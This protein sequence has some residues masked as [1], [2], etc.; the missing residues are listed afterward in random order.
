GSAA[1]GR[2]AA[3]AYYNPAAMTLLG[4]SE[5]LGG[6]AIVGPDTHFSASSAFD[7]AGNRIT[8][9]STVRNDA[10][11]LFFGYAVWAPLPDLR[12][13]V[14]V[15]QPFGQASQYDDAWVGRY[16]ATLAQ[17]TTVNLSFVTGYRVAPW[18]SLG[19]GLDVQYA[20]AD[21]RVAIDFG[22]L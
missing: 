2:D 3:T 11:A 15:N 7:A 9:N 17:L 19:G 21:Q 13:G 20:R 8:R 10:S 1:A 6:L 5:V 16:F 12:F 4:R 22:S 18:L 14:A